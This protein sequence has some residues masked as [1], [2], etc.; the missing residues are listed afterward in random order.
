MRALSLELLGA[1]PKE[2]LRAIVGE[3]RSL[4]KAT[5][6]LPRS[7]A[8]ADG[9]GAADEDLAEIDGAAAPPASEGPVPVS[10]PNLVDAVS[11]APAL[12]AALGLMAAELRLDDIGR[13]DEFLGGGGA[14]V[15]D[16][17]PDKPGMHS[18]G[19]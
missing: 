6:R 5:A 7:A 8:E 19:C 1:V 4:C 3:A 16:Q 2:A 14:L 9:L 17:V 15:P 11:D 18:V 12:G 10:D 13:L